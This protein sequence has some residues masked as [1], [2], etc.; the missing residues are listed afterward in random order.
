MQPRQIL[1]T[2]NPVVAEPYV[3]HSVAFQSDS[4]ASAADSSS[5]VSSTVSSPVSRSSLPT[6]WDT[7]TSSRVSL[8]RRG[9][10]RLHEHAEPAGVQEGDPAQVDDHR[11]AAGQDHRE[12]GGLDRRRT[13]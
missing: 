8:L 3:L 13:R 5:Y 1:E 11:A 4:A 12:Q 10:V 7:T 2:C 9:P 6:G